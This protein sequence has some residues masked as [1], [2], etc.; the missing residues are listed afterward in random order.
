MQDAVVA[1]PRC[2]PPTSAQFEQGEQ[3]YEAERDPEWAV[4]RD[5]L[6]THFGVAHAK[7]EL[8][9]RKTARALGRG[10]AGEEAAFS[11][12]RGYR[13]VHGQIR[14]PP[15]RF[16]ADDEEDDSMGEEDSVSDNNN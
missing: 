1:P 7:K 12:S 15:S 2:I 11:A 16:N 13:D 10:I 6:I 9:W 14:Y 4:L 8:C 5:R 3:S